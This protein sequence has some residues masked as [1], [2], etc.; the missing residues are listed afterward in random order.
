MVKEIFKVLLC[1]IVV[2]TLGSNGLVLALKYNSDSEPKVL[3]FKALK[4]VCPMDSTGA[5]DCFIGY[6]IGSLLQNG[7]LPESWNDDL[8]S[9]VLIPSIKMGIIASGLSTQKKGA[10]SSFPDKESV[11][12]IYSSL[13]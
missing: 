3:G 2:I 8:I 9:R 6:F 10:I 7:N 4:D 12:L 13:E 5:G 11:L 1:S